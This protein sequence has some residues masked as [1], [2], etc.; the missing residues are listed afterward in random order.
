MFNSQN[1]V[2]IQ[3]LYNGD[4]SGYESQNNAD[5]ALFNY[6]SMATHGDFRRVDS[7]FRQLGLYRPKW[8]E[9]HDG[10]RTW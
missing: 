8:D 4:F 2:R 9:I 6:L 5:L 1:G 10:S 3:A 7:L